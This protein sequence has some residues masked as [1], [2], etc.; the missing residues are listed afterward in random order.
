MVRQRAAGSADL[1]YARTPAAIAAAAMMAVPPARSLL[2]FPGLLLLRCFMM[3]QSPW[4]SQGLLPLP[5][6]RRARCLCWVL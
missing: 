2:R 6:H 1:L 5:W 4:P 3:V